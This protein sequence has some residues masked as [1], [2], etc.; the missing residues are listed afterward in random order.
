MIIT[1]CSSKK[2]FSQLDEIEEIL[3][4][5]GY[6]VLK[7]STDDS[8]LLNNEEDSDQK[9]KY[10]LIRQ[11]F[12]KINSSNAIYVYN[13]DKNGLDGYIGGNT[14]LEM[15]KAYDVEIPILLYKQYSNKLPYSEE[16]RALQPIVIGEDWDSIEDYLK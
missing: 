16:L 3:I 4:N 6:E 12:N 9:I 15:G 8:H 5:K 13:D 10:D 11:H 14:F 1:L 2:F 7:P